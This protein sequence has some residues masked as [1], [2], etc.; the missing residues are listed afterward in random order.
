MRWLLL[1][2]MFALSPAG[3][4]APHPHA[5]EI[6]AWFADTFLEFPEDVKDAARDGKRVMI[7]FGQDGC[8]YCRRLLEVNFTQRAIVEKTRGHFVAI[9]LNI[10]GDRE[11]QWTDGRRMSEKELTR[12]LGIQ[13]TPTLLFLDEKGALVARLNGYYPPRRFAAALDFAAGIAGQGLTFEEFMKTAPVE[14][15]GAA[16]S[17]TRI[18]AQP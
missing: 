5:I 17:G 11:V 18:E 6:P 9:A 16:R 14:P 4:Q 1:A 7:Y 13:Y 3:A 8:S 15:G 2:L 10:L 12:A